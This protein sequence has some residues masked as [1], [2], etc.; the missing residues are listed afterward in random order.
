MSGVILFYALQKKSYKMKP[1]IASTF[2]VEFTITS[3]N[4]NLEGKCKEK[5]VKSN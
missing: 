2:K 5:R 4:S 3:F 1:V